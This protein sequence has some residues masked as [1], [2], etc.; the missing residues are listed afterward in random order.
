MSEYKKKLEDDDQK[1]TPIAY[2]IGVLML[3]CSLIP[4]LYGI[5]IKSLNSIIIGGVVIIFSLA[6]MF[7]RFLFDKIKK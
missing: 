1:E 7:F 4:I 6:L 3:C 2:A 5:S